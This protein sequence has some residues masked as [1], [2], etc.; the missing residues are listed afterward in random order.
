MKINKCCLCGADI[1][2]TPQYWGNNPAPLGETGIEVCCDDCNWIKVVPARNE[3]DK[4]CKKYLKATKV[5][6]DFEL[7]LDLFK[8]IHEKQ[9]NDIKNPRKEHKNENRKEHNRTNEL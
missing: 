2:V 8:L 5:C 3:I 1:R 9:E 7:S 6:K 4:V